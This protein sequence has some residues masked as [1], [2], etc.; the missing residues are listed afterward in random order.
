[1]VRVDRYTRHWLRSL[2]AS[3]STCGR[4]LLVVEPIS[5]KLQ[6][7]ILKLYTFSLYVVGISVHSNIRVSRRSDMLKLKIIGDLFLKEVNY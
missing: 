3:V 4:K 5:Q 7:C 2:A 1:V 6:V